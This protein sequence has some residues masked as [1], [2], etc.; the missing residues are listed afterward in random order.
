MQLLIGI[1]KS[2]KSCQISGGLLGY[3][4]ADRTQYFLKTAACSKLEPYFHSARPLLVALR[5][6]NWNSHLWPNH[7]LLCPAWVCCCFV[8]GC[9]EMSPSAGLPVTLRM[10]MAKLLLGCR[11]CACAQ[12]WAHSQTG[13]GVWCALSWDCVAWMRRDGATHMSNNNI[14]MIGFDC[15]ISGQHVRPS[16][17]LPVYPSIYPSAWWST[18]HSQSHSILHFCFYAIKIHFI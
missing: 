7:A 16:V 14:N 18:R 11:D 6:N 3:L 2:L 4:T 10:L 15:F 12:L 9:F 8:W 1:W 5:Q 13:G 17:H